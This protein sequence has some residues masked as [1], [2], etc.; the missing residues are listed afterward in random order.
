MEQIVK[1]FV[2][3][4]YFIDND[5]VVDYNVEQEALI[6]IS[7]KDWIALIPK[8]WSGVDE[9]VAF[10][11]ID[12]DCDVANL[13][14]KSVIMEKKCFQDVVKCEKH[15]Q[16]MYI[17]QHLEILGK[18]EYFIFLHQSGTCNCIPSSIQNET[19]DNSKQSRLSVSIKIS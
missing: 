17:S 18:S 9:Q 12:S 11:T 7:P 2:H 8:G 14:I 19:K 16:L 5:L 1:I 3:Q 13:A 6:N 15:Y 10:K 4:S